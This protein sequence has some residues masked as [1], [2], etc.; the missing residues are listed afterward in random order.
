M[1]DGLV[2]FATFTA[3]VL[4]AGATQNVL[5]AGGGVALAALRAL[6]GVTWLA[7]TFLPMY[8]VFPDADVTVSK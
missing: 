7:V 8:Y 6:V 5:P 1:V 4:V 3:A 2:V